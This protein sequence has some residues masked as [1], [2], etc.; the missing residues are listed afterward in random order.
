MEVL[1]RSG[2]QTRDLQHCL[3]GHEKDAPRCPVHRPYKIARCAAVRPRAVKDGDAQRR[4]PCVEL[5]DPLPQ[6]CG[7]TD[8]DGGSQA[9]PFSP[10]PRGSGVG[11][12]GE[13]GDDLDGLAQ[14]HFI[15]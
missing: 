15:A 2:P 13:K 7:R 3:V 8:Y 12:R 5:R 10:S 11:E 6:D 4:P 14:A 9:A 1:R